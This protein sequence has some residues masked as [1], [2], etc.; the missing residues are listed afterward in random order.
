MCGHGA[1]TRQKLWGRPAT[2]AWSDVNSGTGCG[3]IGH[4]LSGNDSGNFS[5]SIS[6]AI[7]AAISDGVAS[8]V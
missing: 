3:N 5:G 2:L 7:S 8:S 1:S 6:A 4:N